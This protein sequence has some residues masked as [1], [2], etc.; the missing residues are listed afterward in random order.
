MT[1]YLI[2]VA[3][4]LLSSY[5]IIEA[6]PLIIGPSLSIAFPAADN[7]TLPNGIVTVSGKVAHTALL[8][9]NGSPLLRKEDGNF[10]SVLAL[11]RGGS[12]LTLVATD[13]FGRRVTATRSVFVPF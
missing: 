2:I 13:R 11:P 9:L 10:S 5:G 8:T 7:T 6:W 4:G 1:K 12:I 3:L